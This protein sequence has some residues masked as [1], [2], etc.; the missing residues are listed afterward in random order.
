MFDFLRVFLTA[1]SLRVC[2][3]GSP[4]IARVNAAGGTWRAARNARFDKVSVDEARVLL[5]ALPDSDYDEAASKVAKAQSALEATAG[6]VKAGDIPASFD[7]RDAFPGCVHAIR[8][9]GQCG[10]CWAF[11]ASEALSDRFCI[12]TNGTD[13][14][15]LSP[16]QLVSCDWE[17]NM[18]CNGGMLRFAWDY[19]EVFGLVPDDCFPYTAGGG[20]APQ[21]PLSSTCADGTTKW[22][23]VRHSVKALSTKHYTSVEAAQAA[24]MADGPIQVAFNVPQSFMSYKDGVYQCDS[25]VYLG[26]HAVKAVG[27]GTDSD[28]GEDYWLI[29]NSWGSDW[30]IDG[31]FKI[32]RG[33]N[34]C[35]IEAQMFAGLP[36][37]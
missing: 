36:K 29:A 37:V 28:S 27:W 21:C 18:G 4:A 30:G 22:G 24:I 26:G 14:V 31:F 11:S 23:D 25:S 9:Q 7:A 35:G 13:N 10:S 1:L 3:C 5:G 20:N 16:E 8:D 2:V 19:M 6:R 12:A 15:V 32:T 17:G 33:T 34:A